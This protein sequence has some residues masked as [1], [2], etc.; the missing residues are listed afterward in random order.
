MKSRLVRFPSKK[1]TTLYVNP[2]YVVSVEPS[3]VPPD[4]DEI[5]GVTTQINTVGGIVWVKCPLEDV[6]DRLKQHD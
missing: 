6:V 3:T 4:V 2:A 1:G 5:E